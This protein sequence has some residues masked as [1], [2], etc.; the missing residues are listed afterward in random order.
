MTDMLYTLLIYT[1][2]GLVG[3]IIIG[4][5]CLCGYSLSTKEENH[6]EA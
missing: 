5:A 1:V 6:G 4:A 2:I 3:L